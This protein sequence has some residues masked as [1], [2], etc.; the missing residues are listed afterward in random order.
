[1]LKSIWMRWKRKLWKPK[2][3]HRLKRKR[4]TARGCLTILATSP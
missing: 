4:S 3:L 2:L 1:M